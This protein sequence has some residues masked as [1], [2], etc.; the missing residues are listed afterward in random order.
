MPIVFT[1]VPLIPSVVLGIY[2][3]LSYWMNE[4]LKGF[5]VFKVWSP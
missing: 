5:E 3:E 4:W 1:T 2:Q